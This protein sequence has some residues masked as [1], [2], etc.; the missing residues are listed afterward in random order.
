LDILQAALEGIALRLSLIADQLRPITGE[1][2]IVL[3]GGG[4]LDASPA[5]AQIVA[6]ALNRPLQMLTVTETTARGVAML[7]LSDLHKRPLKD[8]KL[9][10]SHEVEPKRKDVEVLRNARKR[11]QEMYAK[12]VKP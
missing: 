5:W 1:E 11:Q 12:L 4:A 9:V 10:I 6:N 7:V 8:F 2:P 3:V